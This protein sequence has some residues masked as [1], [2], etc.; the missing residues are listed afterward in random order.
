MNIRN[1]KEGDIVTRNAPVRYEDERTG[2]GSFTGEALKLVGYDEEAKL[3]I[4]IQRSDIIDLSFA[5]DAW[6]E[7]WCMYPSSLL[8]KAIHFIKSKLLKK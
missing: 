4:L 3:I 2:D 7:G 8:D 6:D 5:R 1:F